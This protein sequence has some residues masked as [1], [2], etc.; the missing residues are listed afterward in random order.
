[1][2][3]AN[4]SQEEIDTYAQEWLGNGNKIKAAWKVVFPNSKA[5]EKSKDEK[6]SL[7]HNLVKVQ[8]RI[9]QLN[10]VAAEK[11]NEVY[12]IT[13]ESLLAEYEEARVKALEAGQISASVSAITGK[14][15]LCGFDVSKIE[16]SGGDGAPIKT[17]STFNFIPVGSD[18]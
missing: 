11:A 6:S 13:A 7:F 5:T 16:L 3:Q 8:S 18:H 10:E 1:M 12:G 15:K 17:E 2:S 14:V 9:G 4:P